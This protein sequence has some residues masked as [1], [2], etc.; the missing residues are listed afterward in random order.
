MAISLS[1]FSCNVFWDQEHFSFVKYSSLSV[2]LVSFLVLACQTN[3]DQQTFLSLSVMRKNIHNLGH[4]VS[5]H[6]IIIDDHQSFVTTTTL[7][8]II[9]SQIK[10]TTIIITTIPIITMTPTI[11]TNQSLISIIHQY[12]I[13][14]LFLFFQSMMCDMILWSSFFLLKL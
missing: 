14:N 4:T 2:V 10:T 9:L 1:C 3:F 5:F 7:S 12:Q 11:T 6:T 8:T 13:S